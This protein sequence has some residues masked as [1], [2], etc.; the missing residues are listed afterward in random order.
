MKNNRDAQLIGCISANFKC[1]LTIKG[2]GHIQIRLTP[3]P[4]ICRP[5]RAILP[6]CYDY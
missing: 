4:M 1:Y 5:S 3:Y 6:S 2:K